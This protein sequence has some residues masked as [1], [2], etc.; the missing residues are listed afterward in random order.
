MSLVLRRVPFVRPL[1]SSP[2]RASLKPTV[3]KKPFSELP[4]RPA[5]PLLPTTQPDVDNGKVPRRR[6]QSFLTTNKFVAQG[7]VIRLSSSR[8]DLPNSTRLGA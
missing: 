5:A 2:P 8:A 4:K 1:H 6:R 3:T 7:I